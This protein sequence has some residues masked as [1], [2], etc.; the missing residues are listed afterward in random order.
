MAMDL[1]SVSW[2][3]I[4]CF[5]CLQS[6]VYSLSFRWSLPEDDLLMH[7]AGSNIINRAVALAKEMGL[8]HRYIYQNYANSSQ[9]VFGGYGDENREK[10]KVIQAK[11]DPEGVFSKLQPGYFKV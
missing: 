10:L 11:Y 8:N 2:C 4:P 9:D 5:L 3:G 6:I 7:T 1:C